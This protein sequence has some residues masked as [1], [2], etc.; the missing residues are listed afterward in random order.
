MR[1]P[2]GETISGGRVRR[3]AG[4]IVAAEVVADENVVCS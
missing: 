4:S 1:A 2:L 3:I